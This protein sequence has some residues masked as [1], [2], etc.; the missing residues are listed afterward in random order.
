MKYILFDVKNMAITKTDKSPIVSGAV[1]YF[2]IEFTFDEEFAGI[3]G[4]KAVEF[5]KKNNKDRRDL[6]DRKCQIPNWILADKEQFQMR[7][8][9]GNTIGTKWASVSIEEGGIIMPEEPEEEAPPSMEYVKTES[10]ENAAPY[11][12][13]AT[14]GLEFSKDG[15]TW[16]SGVIGVPEVPKKPEGGKYLRAYGDWI[17]QEERDA[18]SEVKVNGEAITPIDGAVDI[19]LSTYA[20]TADVASTYAEKTTVDGLQTLTGTASQ[21]TALDY[22][23]TDTTTIVAKINEIVGA[24]QARGVSTE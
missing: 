15:E 3:S 19:D 12:R 23:E 18:V 9:T 4:A 11:L 22:S 2:G 6:V 21:L 13:A 17:L 16:E 10:G 20:K 24:L 1:D 5:I 14:N 8:I 7:V